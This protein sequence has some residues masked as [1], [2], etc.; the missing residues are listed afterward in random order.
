MEKKIRIG[1]DEYDALMLAPMAGRTDSA[2]RTV[3]R[4]HG[5][6]YST[7]EMISA[8]AVTYGDEKTKALA[9]I[10]PDEGPVACQIFGHEPEI[11]A[12]AV[13]ILLEDYA[14]AGVKPCAFDINM[15]CPV[16][17]IV[18]NG[19]GSALMR[20]PRLAGEMISS[21]VGAA[22]DVP[23][24]VKLRLGWDRSSINVVELA[25]LAEEC[26]AAAIC[27]HA[28]TRSQM[29]EPS[30]DWSYIKQVKDAVTI[31]VI[32]N[33]DVFSGGDAVR[34]FDETGCDAV[35]V[36][37]G[38]LGNPWIFDEIRA[39][40]EGKEWQPPSKRERVTAAIAH[41]ELEVARKGEYKAVQEMRSHTGC[42]TKGLYGSP[43]VRNE[44]NL[45]ETF[46]DVKALLL[47]LLD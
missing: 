33:G 11:A 2:F 38:A 30:A 24:T 10:R 12:R 37:R 31:P 1:N 35:A 15:G 7:T 42:Y 17:K 23:V 32:G 28:R 41:L 20:D 44:L 3:C 9:A 34:M 5:M 43:R 26:G 21:T 8:K 27:V 19:E 18:R 47:S 40:L 13:S 22:G 14:K 16:P 6:G 29:Y 39:R 46:T 4:A 25:K 45:A 36:A